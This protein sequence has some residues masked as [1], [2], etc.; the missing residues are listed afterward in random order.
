[1]VNRAIWRKNHC[2]ERVAALVTGLK[3]VRLF[4]LGYLKQRVYNLLPT[5][6]EDLKS[7]LTREIE[8]IPAQMLKD[9]FLNFQK[10]RKLL[11][12][13]GGG[14]NE[15]KIKVICTSQYSGGHLTVFFR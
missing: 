4:F 9:T 12:F 1:M 14:H 8:N 11:I 7:N 13:A 6:L 5:T 10:R 3:S 15:K 2:Q